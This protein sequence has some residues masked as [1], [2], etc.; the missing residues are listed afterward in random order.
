[1]STGAQ[2]QGTPPTQA[3]QQQTFETTWNTLS[4][5]M[6]DTNESPPLADWHRLLEACEFSEDGPSKAI[7]VL[8]LMRKLETRATAASYERVLQ[9]CNEHG[10][11]AAAFHLVELMFEDK[12]KLGDV[13]LPDGME[14][15]LRSILPPEAFE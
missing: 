14:E 11:R 4:A 7:W 3:P 1:M 9:V 12:V 5:R 6:R 13:Q 10:D 8:N 15:T 2:Q